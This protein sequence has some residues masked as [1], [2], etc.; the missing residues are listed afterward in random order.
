MNR[1]LP[2]RISQAER[3]LP[4]VVERRR[5]RRERLKDRLPFLA[6]TH[7][8]AVAAMVLHGEPKFEEPLLQSWTRTLTHHYSKPYE[9]MRQVCRIFNKTEAE[10]GWV[11][12]D[13][14]PAIAELQAEELPR[15]HIHELTLERY[16]Y[17]AKSMY[18]DIMNGAE[19]EAARFTEIFKTAPTW[20]LKFTFTFLDAK[21]LKIDLPDLSTAPE[22]GDIGLRDAFRWP[23]LP[24]GVM[25]EG[26]L[27]P[28]Q[29]PDF[30]CST[31]DC[32]FILETL[33]KPESEV[34]R[35]EWRRL[36]ALGLNRELDDTMFVFKRHEAK[37]YLEELKKKALHV[38][39]KRVASSD[40]S[41]N[42]LLRIA[43]DSL[44]QAGEIDIDALALNE[45]TGQQPRQEPQEHIAS[46]G[47]GVA[48]AAP[49]VVT[50]AALIRKIGGWL[51]AIEHLKAAEQRMLASGELKK[52]GRLD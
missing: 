50:K 34:T 13:Y 23:L 9:A 4:G 35:I 2:R 1:D 12:N 10:Q 32:M 22:F 14:E 43:E 38:L 37:W 15:Y 51:E 24:L 26:H 45:F 40:I 44:T 21:I 6:R 25:T 49:H 41:E 19:D 33:A 28:P 52:P 5:K 17:A 30:S 3:L 20:L 7:A 46:S 11:V 18:S 47:G 29:E 31:E 42:L 16:V 27:A 8:T 36:L 39:F 48:S